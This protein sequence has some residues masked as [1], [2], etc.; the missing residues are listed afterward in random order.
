MNTFRSDLSGK[1]FPEN[2]KFPLKISDNL[3][4]IL[5]IKRI[6]IFLKVVF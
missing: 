2:E 1:E 4:F 3:C 6:Q 5:S